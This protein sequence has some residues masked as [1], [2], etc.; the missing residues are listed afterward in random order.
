MSILKSRSG[1]IQTVRPGTRIESGQT[2]S[3]GVSSVVDGLIKANEDTNSPKSGGTPY[4]G[5][6]CFG[7]FTV[8]ENLD[9]ALT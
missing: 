5:A 7:L 2:T 4:D 6:S 8:D 1:L 9:G 3:P